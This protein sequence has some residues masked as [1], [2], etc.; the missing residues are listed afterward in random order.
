MP[1]M[2]AISS[3]ATGLQAAGQIVKSLVG[4][5]INS[6]VQSKVIELQGVIMG[7]QGDALAAQSEQFSLLQ[8]IR[9]LEEKVAKVEAWN[10][11]KERYELHEFPTGTFAYLLKA[12]AATSEPPHRVCANCYQDG[13]KSILQMVRR[14]HG[15]ELV[16]CHRCKDTFLLSEFHE[17]PI[18]IRST[19]YY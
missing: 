18:N 3:A 15:G 4:L 2:M 13:H 19:Q 9:E 14:R 16:E 8:R 5:K 17:P 6:E 10:T 12:D 7:A 11:E 1:D